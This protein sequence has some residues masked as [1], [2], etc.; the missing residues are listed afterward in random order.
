M[1][2]LHEAAKPRRRRIDPPITDPAYNFSGVVRGS[3]PSIVGRCTTP[4]DPGSLDGVMRPPKQG[5]EAIASDILALNR[6]LLRAQMDT[7][8]P[9]EKVD[10]L[11]HHLREAIRILLEERAESPVRKVP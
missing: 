1:E 4:V 3:R 8:R 10:A 5:P 7:K 2:V 9:R 6:A 11:C